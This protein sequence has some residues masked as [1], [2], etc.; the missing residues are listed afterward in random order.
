MSFMLG[1][2][3]DGLFEG[4]H[5]VQGLYADYQKIQATRREVAGAD[6]VKEA[7]DAQDAA[8]KAATPA[9]NPN[10]TTNTKGDGPAP[11]T[12]S[13]GP[14]VDVAKVKETP[15][16]QQPRLKSA[17]AG[18]KVARDIAGGDPAAGN[19]TNT[20]AAMPAAADTPT[21][22]SAAVSPTGALGAPSPLVGIGPNAPPNTLKLQPSADQVAADRLEELYP[23]TAR[24]NQRGDTAP[25]M[26]QMAGGGV[27]PTTPMVLGADGQPKIAAGDYS[28][29]S[30]RANQN[31]PPTRSAV[32]N[33]MSTNMAGGGA[34]T[35]QPGAPPAGAPPA[36]DASAAPPPT[37]VGARPGTA[38]PSLGA[39]MLSAMNPIS[40]ASAESLPPPNGEEQDQTDARERAAMAPPVAPSTGVMRPGGAP[41]PLPSSSA[42]PATP[43]AAPSASSAPTAPA[44]PAPVTTVAPASKPVA[45]PPSGQA[46]APAAAGATVS[47]PAPRSAVAPD[48]QGPSTQSEA[49]PTVVKPPFDPRP[50]AAVVQQNPRLAEMIDDVA[51]TYGITPARLALHGYLESDLNEHEKPGTSGEIGMMQIMPSTAKQLDP[52]GRL[53]PA[54]TRGGLELAAIK[55]RQDD[56]RNGRDMPASIGA[57]QGGQGSVDAIAHGQGQYHPGTVAYMVKAF[58]GQHLSA[59]NLLPG[60][61]V[62]PKALVQAGVQGGPDGFLHFIAQQGS[63]GQPMTDKWRAAEN[64]LSYAALARGDIE[65]AS[66]ARDYVLQM[67]QQGTSTSL[68]NAYKA[69]DAG[70]GQGAAQQLARAHAFFPDGSMG[71]FGVDGKGNVYGQSISENDPSHA[72]GDPFQVT[73]ETL[74]GMLVQ[75]QDPNKF[76]QMVTQ[77]RKENADI[78]LTLDHGIYY[79]GLNVTRQQ[80]S[81]DRLQA[82]REQLA[83]TEDNRR[84]VAGLHAQE[85]RERADAAQK[86]ADGNNETRL[87]VAG[88]RGDPNDPRNASVDKE[89]SAIFKTDNEDLLDVNKQPPSMTQLGG[90]STLYHDL[91][92]NGG[93]QSAAAVDA[94][95]GLV[96]GTYTLDRNPSDGT[97]GLVPAHP[98]GTAP[99]PAISTVS[100]PTAQRVLTMLH[101]NKSTP[102]AGPGALAGAA[103]PPRSSSAMMGS[104]G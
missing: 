75:T 15:D 76:R 81:N 18:L 28:S 45:A 99:G 58:P 35:T 104:A 30:A 13:E 22:A 48:Q 85:V 47:L 64:A 4:A 31:Y 66:H 88:A 74:Q 94:A 6:A 2:G 40:S 70:D 53:D 12:T 101:M 97:W 61:D 11:A 102:V 34:N 43:P 50:Y 72:L 38:Q 37:P 46:Q 19:A 84:Y 62:D 52:T 33:P 100:G 93:M 87:A 16:S 7:Q 39:R 68:I 71:R 98:A 65:G 63:P 80:M 57:Y 23:G 56:A 95:H 36:N 29:W 51:K 54:T 60:I 44:A 59:T 49:T 9:S 17:I 21:A 5:A 103:P 27:G 8:D 26:P 14:K 86:I 25:P 67:S 78:A 24:A 32:G 82:R 1:S 90:M 41:A 3:M 10:A 89:G 20:G 83:D 79:G 77:Q 69:L 73:K 96:T 42:A 91:R 55:I 92:M